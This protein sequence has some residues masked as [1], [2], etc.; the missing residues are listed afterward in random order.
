MAGDSSTEEDYMS[1]VLLTT[2][3]DVKPGSLSSQKIE[4]LISYSS[5]R[6]DFIDLVF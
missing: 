4:F 5:S 1:D 2:I 3:K 6:N